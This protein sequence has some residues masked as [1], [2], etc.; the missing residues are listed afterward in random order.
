MTGYSSYVPGS[1]T[2]HS[3]KV[4]H[5][6]ATR[7]RT[8]DFA[9]S[10]GL[11]EDGL[12]WCSMAAQAAHNCCMLQYCINVLLPAS[13]CSYGADTERMDAKTPIENFRGGQAD[14]LNGQ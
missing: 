4:G 10:N 12:F 9:L 1:G 5:T 14:T 8:F 7:R 3:L 11:S 2:V 6:S 13:Q